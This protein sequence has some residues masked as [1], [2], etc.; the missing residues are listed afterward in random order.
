M[1]SCSDERGHRSCNENVIAAAQQIL[2]HA[3]TQTHVRDGS[4]VAI[5]GQDKRQGQDKRRGAVR[6]VKTPNK[7]DF[8]SALLFFNTTNTT[9]ERKGGFS[10]ALHFESTESADVSLLTPKSKGAKDGRDG[11]TCRPARRHRS[12]ARSRV[13]ALSSWFYTRDFRRSEN[14]QVGRRRARGKEGK[15]GGWQCGRGGGRS[16]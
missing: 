10:I 16:K 2:R 5:K 1:G 15:G 12:L 14:M 8:P 13:Q 6:R 11:G 4:L 7:V 9:K 3:R